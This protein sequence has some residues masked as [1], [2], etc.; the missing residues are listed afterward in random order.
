MNLKQV[1]KK[2]KTI[3]NVKKITHAMELVAAVKM[4]KS[5]EE[6]LQSK[7][8]Y[9]VLS[10]VINRLTAVIDPSYSS[11]LIEK[12]VKKRLIILISTNKGLCG[13]FNFNLFNFLIRELSKNTHLTTDF[14]TVG[15]KGSEF[16]QHYGAQILA[17]YGTNQPINVVPAIFNLVLERFLR[18]DYQEVLLAYNQFISALRYQPN[19]KRI[20]PVKWQG[21][22]EGKLEENYLIEPG[23][24][25]IID[26]LLRDFVENLIREAI[27]SSQAGEH[28]ARMLAMKNATEN[29][30]ELIYQLTLMA[31]KLRQEKITYELLDM[32]T[33]KESVENN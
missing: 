1:R 28:S 19:I 33:A 2:I 6:A 29:A 18:G 10:S 27:I 13:S 31:N 8:Y 7:P 30:G 20:L 32:I 24:E 15:R 22:Q 4:K 16:V 25:K 11:L 14:I 9:D 3:G 26:S 5:Q 12:P 21:S 17:H 23:P